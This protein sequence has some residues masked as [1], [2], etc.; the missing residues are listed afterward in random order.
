MRLNLIILSGGLVTKL[1]TY[2]T[3]TV[4]GYGVFVRFLDGSQGLARLA[5]GG[6]IILSAGTFRNPQ[7]LELSGIGNKDILSRFGI[8]VQLDLPAVGENYE[9]Q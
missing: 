8:P 7:L 6:E 4:T 5:Q 2:N 1:G 9:D 3:S